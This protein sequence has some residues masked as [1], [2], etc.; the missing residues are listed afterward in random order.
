MSRFGKI[1]SDNDSKNLN[2][3]V[4]SS[5][6]DRYTDI[7]EDKFDEI[8]E[9]DFL[10]NTK[11]KYEN[12]RRM[13]FNIFMLVYEDHIDYNKIRPHINSILTK[14]KQYENDETIHWL[15]ECEINDII[16]KRTYV[17]LNLE[18]S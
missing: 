6:T 13:C 4:K 11:V 2:S 18:T 7:K 1:I 8:G 10:N 12:E 5:K 3:H 16:Y 17:Y 14:R 9:Y 15:G